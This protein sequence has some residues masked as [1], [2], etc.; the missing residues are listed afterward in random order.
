V[1]VDSD[2][3]L[4]HNAARHVLFGAAIGQNKAT[5]IAAIANKILDG[6]PVAQAIAADFL[7]PGDQDAAITNTINNADLVLDFS[8]SIAVSRKLAAARTATR[9]ISEFLNP[10]GDSLIVAVE[11]AGRTTRLDWLEMLHYRAV[12][13]ELKLRR[14]LWSNDSRVRYCSGCRDL[15][16]QL[17]QDDVSVWSGTASRA[18]KQLTQAESAALCIYIRDQDGSIAFFNPEI[19]RLSN[20]SLNDWTIRLDEWLLEKLATFRNAKLPNETGGVLLGHFDTYRRA[21]YL[22]DVM[23]SPPDSCEWPTTYVRGCSGLR[24]SLLEVQKNTSGQICYVGEWHSHPKGASIHPSDADLQAY[25][26]LVGL[27]LPEALPAIM[28]IIGDEKQF[29]FT[30]LTIENG[31]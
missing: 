2:L 26:W 14:S 25:G 20:V 28:L 13:S 17:A 19:A 31:N 7:I 22:V 3:F 9:N 23:P 8:A 29:G 11:D 24:E 15:S 4:P 10:T 6:P 5:T 1:L 18:I 27:M 21:C 12:L 16:V 30:R